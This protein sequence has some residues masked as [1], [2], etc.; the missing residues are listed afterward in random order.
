MALAGLVMIHDE[1]QTIG[2]A[3]ESFAQVCDPI[4]GLDVGSSDGADEIARG[5]GVELHRQEWRSHG[6]AG[7]ELLRLARGRADYA[8]L[9]GATETVEA[10]APLPEKLT[11]PLYEL[12]TITEGA[13]IRTERIYDTKIDWSWPGPV[14][15]TVEPPFWDEREELAALVI[16]THDD[17]G[18]RPEKLARYRDELEAWLLEHPDDARSTYYLANTYYHLRAINAAAGLFK[19]RAAMS[20]GDIEAWHALYMAGVCEMSYNFEAGAH[21][22]LDA[23]VR[24][25]GRM[26][27]LQTL[28]HAC[29]MVRKQTPLPT[30][31]ELQWLDPGA[32]LG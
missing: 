28:E 20:N 23:F 27:T 4:I 1:A 16:T 19:R 18:R 26:E 21:M 31:G 8:L 32:Y 29:H 7:E 25:P 9:F 14:H 13:I 30:S 3:V 11:A 22:L 10:R 12:E 5:L 24:K 17:D 2:R 15:S 6:A